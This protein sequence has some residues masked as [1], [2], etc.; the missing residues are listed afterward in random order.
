[1]KL[2]WK[3]SHC[4]V[5][6]V[7]GGL[8]IEHIIPESFGGVLTCCFICRRCNS[9]F[10][11][12]F[13]AGARLA[14]ELR[15]A[16]FG[17]RNSLPELNDKLERGG[18]YKSLFEDQISKRKLRKDGHLGISELK[19]GSLIVPEPDA[20]G[21]LKSIMQKRG[22][23]DSEIKNALTMWEDAP[24]GHRVDLGAGVIVK[25]WQEHPSTPTYTEPS[26]SPLVP[27]K[28]AF[29]FAALLVGGLIY[30]DAFGSLRDVLRK[31]DRNLADEMVTH[32]RASKPDAFH[33][34]AFEGNH[35]VAQF[36]VRFFGLL[37]Y[38]VRFPKIAIDHPP[39]VY[40]HRLDTGDDWVHLADG[41]D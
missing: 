25:K 28:I 20:L 24:A 8:S 18:E 34:I 7:S 19:D 2:P 37:A 26:L 15:K 32:N 9:S 27:L 23:S 6:G 33:G 22:I 4:I 5:C 17:L 38:T 30:D 12:G 36:Q 13:E 39:A 40:T 11:S 21:Q 3:H 14:P 29:E 31:Q 10:G 41:A 35:E 1:M 16:A